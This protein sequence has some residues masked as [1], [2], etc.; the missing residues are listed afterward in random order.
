MNHLNHKTMKLKINKK[1][2]KEIA[3]IRKLI[4]KHR[5]EEDEAIDKLALAMGIN[6]DKVVEDV[7]QFELLHDYIYND[8]K[9]M[10]DLE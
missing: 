7:E 1:H 5:K 9:W 2:Q 6:I 10:V 8:S 4:E 3:K